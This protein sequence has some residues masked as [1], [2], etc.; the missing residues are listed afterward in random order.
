[1]R[2]VAQ[3]HIVGPPPESIRKSRTQ[4]DRKKCCPG[5]V[6]TIKF[7]QGFAALGLFWAFVHLF[8]VHLLTR[9][10]IA[11]ASFVIGIAQTT[12]PEGYVR[13]YAAELCHRLNSCRVSMLDSQICRES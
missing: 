7:D 8:E 1:M 10:R 2:P 3:L 6:K 12:L 11:A 9:F 5:A 4:K 13:A